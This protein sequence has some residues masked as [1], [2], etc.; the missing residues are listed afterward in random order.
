MTESPVPSAAIL[1]TRPGE[2]S[3]SKVGTPE[4]IFLKVKGEKIKGREGKTTV[5]YKKVARASP[6]E[7]LETQDRKWSF[8]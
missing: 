8:A 1:T 6:P 7:K 2:I 3:S 5:L 4:V